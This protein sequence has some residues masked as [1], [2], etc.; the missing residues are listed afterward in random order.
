MSVIIP[1]RNEEQAIGPT[2]ASVLGEAGEDVEVVIADSDST[3]RT[4]AIA[5]AA[6]EHHPGPSSIVSCGRGRG[7][8]M[9][10]GAAASQ[11]ALGQRNPAMHGF[12]KDYR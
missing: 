2:L 9:N 5:R 4:V 10:A 11:D 6:L 7:H 1:A 3:D 12:F 8:A